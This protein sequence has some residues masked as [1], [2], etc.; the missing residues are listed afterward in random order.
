MGVFVEVGVIPEQVIRQSDPV[1]HRI[2]AM[3]RDVGHQRG[4]QPGDAV[5]E[6]IE[7]TVMDICI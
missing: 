4:V 7:E 2:V 6:L 3:F 1:A 5:D